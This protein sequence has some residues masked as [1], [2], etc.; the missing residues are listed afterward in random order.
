LVLVV[1]K[2]VPRADVEHVL[3]AAAL[4]AGVRDRREVTRTITNGLRRG[5][6]R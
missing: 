6:V 3:A 1:E 5:G 2:G 4:A